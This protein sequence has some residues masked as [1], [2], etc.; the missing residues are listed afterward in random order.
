MQKFRLL[1]VEDET[2]YYDLYKDTIEINND[3]NELQFEVEFAENLE[4]AIKFIESKH[5]DGAVIDLKIDSE[6]INKAEGNKIIS[7]IQSKIR[8]PLVIYTGYIGDLEQDICE[9]IFLRIFIK[10]TYN[11]QNI[12]EHFIEISN[13]KLISVLGKEGIINSYLLDLFWKKVIDQYDYWDTT[14]GVNNEGFERVISRY[15]IT[16]LSE[17][18]GIN[19]EGEFDQYHPSEVYIYPPVKNKVF[20][21]D[22]FKNGADKKYII[23]SPA[24]DLANGKAKQ[25]I[26]CEIIESNNILEQHKN[27][28]NNKNR[29]I[30]QLKQEV[31]KLDSEIKETN[32]LDKYNEINLK[33]DQ[34]NKEEKKL[35]V[36]EA[37]IKNIINNNYKLAWHYLPK[38][39]LFDGGIIDFANISSIP[40][41]K[42]EEQILENRIC[43]VAPSFMKDIVSRF[44][45]YYARQG[46]PN[47]D[48]QKIFEEIISN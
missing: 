22:M 2:D 35:E 42:M 46:Q 25:I 45:Q 23:L 14:Y 20:T 5:Y 11:F 18:L 38:T 7:L 24:C 31:D 21:G 9:N 17:M 8:I 47:F 43:S 6:D 34:L 1:V 41:K 39:N 28:Y 13:N 29:K 26:V 3:K 12:L 36:I 33:K 4:Q 48:N 30:E 32:R 19:E 27:G 10:G 40:V 37:T 15:I 16:H 44:S